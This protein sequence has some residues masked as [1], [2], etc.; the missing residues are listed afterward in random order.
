MSSYEKSEKERKKIIAKEKEKEFEKRLGDNPKALKNQS[1][2]KQIVSWIV[3]FFIIFYGFE[4]FLFLVSFL[5]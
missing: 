2:F 5:Q 1:K 3:L 4:F